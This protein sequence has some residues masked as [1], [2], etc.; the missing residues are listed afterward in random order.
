MAELASIPACAKD[1]LRRKG[2]PMAS[3]WHAEKA[4]RLPYVYLSKL[5]DVPI[6]QQ[7]LMPLKLLYLRKEYGFNT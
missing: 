1:G 4:A 2:M 3:Q 6:L 7:H 5:H